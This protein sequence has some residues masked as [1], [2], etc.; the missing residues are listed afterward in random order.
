MPLCLIQLQHNAL[1]ILHSDSLIQCSLLTGKASY[2]A[3][4]RTGW[5][6]PASDKGVMRPIF[7]PHKS[8]NSIAAA[9]SYANH[10]EV[11]RL[12]GARAQPEQPSSQSVKTLHGILGTETLTKSTSKPMK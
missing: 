7:L 3:E 11:R 9:D 10:H 2:T 8:K 4:F 1:M 6:N 12:F 5:L